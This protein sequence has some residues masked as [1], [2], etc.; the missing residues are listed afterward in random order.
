M[1]VGRRFHGRD[2]QAAVA[3]GTNGRL[4]RLSAQKYRTTPPQRCLH[5]MKRNRFVGAGIA[6]GIAAGSLISIFRGDFVLW[7]AT[8]ICLGAAGGAALFRSS[9][10]DGAA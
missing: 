7:I 8:G 2:V 9:G 10:H 3:G 1:P 4:L 5:A 6:F